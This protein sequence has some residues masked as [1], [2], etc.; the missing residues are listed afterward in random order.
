MRVL[1]IHH[2]FCTEIC[3]VDAISIV[4]VSPLPDITVIVPREYDPGSFDDINASG[5][6][7]LNTMSRYVIAGNDEEQAG[8][9]DEL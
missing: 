8:V 5:S 6:G 3:P 9:P 2:G 1:L 7:R 4:R